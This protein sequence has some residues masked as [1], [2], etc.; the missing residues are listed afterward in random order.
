MHGKKIAIIVCLILL[1]GVIGFYLGKTNDDITSNEIQNQYDESTVSGDIT[2]LDTIDDEVMD[3]RSDKQEPVTEDEPV[4]DN[5]KQE[6]EL[7]ED[8]K[9]EEQKDK[10][11]LPEF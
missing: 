3:G 4:E 7:P 1:S 5:H 8:S 2:V 6:I 10:Y 9:K 11:E